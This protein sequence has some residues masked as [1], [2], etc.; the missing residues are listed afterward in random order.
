M[1]DIAANLATIRERIAAALRRSGRD[2]AAVT[3][4]AASKGMPAAVIRAAIA[5]GQRLFGEN[6]L[7]EAEAKMDELAGDEATWHFIGRLQSN[8][9]RPAAERFAM[10]ETV[11]RLKLARALA[12]HAAEVGRVLPVLVQVNIGREPQKAGVLPEEA[13]E[14]LAAINVLPALRVMGLMAM[15]PFF[16]DPEGARPYFRATRQ[17][18]TELSGRGLL[19]QHGPL[20]LSMGMSGDFEAAVEEGATLVRVGAA[21]FGPRA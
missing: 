21:L 5:A 2:P 10:V 4:V 6:Y 15:P 3:L 12:R 19:G 20:V 18:A 17:L 1:T 7:Q 14:L 8:K 11:D 9:A 16:D 13:A